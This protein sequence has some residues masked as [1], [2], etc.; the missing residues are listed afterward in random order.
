MPYEALMG[1]GGKGMRRACAR[2]RR[3]AHKCVR[4]PGS[5]AII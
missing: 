4:F 1:E 3:T 2:L 5:Y